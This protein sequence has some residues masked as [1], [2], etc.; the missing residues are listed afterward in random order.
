M[1]WLNEVSSWLID[2]AVFGAVILALGSIAVYSCR[3]PIYRIRIIQWTFTGCLLVPLL[4]QL[5]QVPSYHMA[6]WSLPQENDQEAVQQPNDAVPATEPQTG[7]REVHYDN[8]RFESVYVKTSDDSS[9]S[10]AHI[11]TDEG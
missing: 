1:M 2:S 5:D 10:L 8:E 3:E 9:A 7:R 11:A 4:H 6:L